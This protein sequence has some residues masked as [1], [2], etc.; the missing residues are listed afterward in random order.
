MRHYPTLLAI[1][2]VATPALAG[3]PDR[4]L[5]VQLSAPAVGG[6]SLRS[7]ALPAAVRGRFAALGLLPAR[8]FATARSAETADHRPL[9]DIFDF[10]PERVVLVEAPDSSLATS[11]LAA[12][13]G[14]AMVDW[15]ERNAIRS[16]ARVTDGL[17]PVPSA[18]TTLD[19]LANDPYLRHGLQYGLWNQ[20]PQLG[21]TR[22]DVHA[23]EAW[24]RSVGDNSI[25]LAV[26]DTGIDPDQPE[27]G[28]LMP[29]GTPRIVDAVNVTDDTTGGVLDVY[30]HGTAV[31]GVMAARTNDG[32][33]FSRNSGVAGVCGGDGAANAG[34]RIVPIKIT[35]GHSGDATSFDIAQALVHAADVGAR[36][37]NC[38]FAGDAPSRLERLSLTYALYKGCVPVCAAGNSGFDQ[39]RLALYPAAYARDG[40]AIS[41]G[42]SDEQD[43]RVV[44]SSYP[45]GL[46]LVAPGIDVLTTYMTYPS[47]FGASYPGYVQASGTS[48]AAPFVTG[49]VGLLA[50]ERADLVDDD[51][52]HV[53]RESAD[54]IGAPGI[55]EETGHGRLNLDRML[56]FVRPGV[57][58]WHD[59]TMADSFTVEGQGTL[60]VGESS[61][62]TMGLHPGSTWSTRI[63]AYA[64]VTVP[65][66]FLA[67]TGVWLRVAGT[68]AAR[69]DYRLPYFTPSA[70]VLRA[71]ATQAT[72]RGFLYRVSEDSCDTCDDRYVPLAPSNVRFAFT[73]MGPVDRPP[74]LSV[75]RPAPNSV[76][77]PG[78]LM[79]VGWRA[80]DPDQVTRIRVTFEPGD[81]R[82]GPASV[83]V[84]EAAGDAPGAGFTLP[85]LGPADIRGR[86]VVTASDEHGHADQTSVAVPFTL[87]GGSCSAPLAE[88]RATP[89]PFASGL[90]LFAPGAGTLRVIDASGR[91]VRELATAGGAVRW[92]GRD[93]RGSS[94]AAGIYWVRYEGVRG[95]VTRRVVKLGR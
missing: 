57:G 36:A 72:F 33:H 87:R 34:C 30:Y 60:V 48:F 50:A 51:Y 63:A 31:A 91:V 65:D 11:A 71:T 23:I 52:Q 95:M 92:D 20:G 15:A 58:I 28:G 9:P 22:A 37:I 74:T 49:A 83:L 94:A 1:L 89:T 77:A 27:L 54:D 44:F 2:I 86:L 64:T 38:S 29:D 84:G 55:D 5:V 56:A 67:V 4:E 35:P 75:T 25:K 26:A 70:E 40:L 53:I 78:Q 3:A 32:P 10:H 59:E 62:G 41:V 7:G 82:G 18:A 93:D 68:M 46:D 12:L 16:V 76:G 6:A 24:H 61:P 13:Q 8:T 85:C 80:S 47:Y 19:T 39:P 42:A 45:P 43:H 14:D 81:P 21:I 17:R 90:D 73:V 88:F 69:G 79:L 66:T